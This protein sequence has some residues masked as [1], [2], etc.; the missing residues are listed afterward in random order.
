MSKINHIA[1]QDW[2]YVPKDA[3]PDFDPARNKR[4]I[5]ET[6]K[7]SAAHRR[8]KNREFEAGVKERSEAIANYVESLKQGS[9]DMGI[10]K[11]FGR[12]HLAYLQGKDIMERI[13][14]GLQVIDEKK[15]VTRESPD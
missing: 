5:E 3:D 11:Y 7:K 4:I 13:K 15:K 9:R 10:E 12:K 14:D 6:I 1:R 2:D 8:K